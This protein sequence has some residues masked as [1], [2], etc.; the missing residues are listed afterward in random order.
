[1][2]RENPLQFISMKGGEEEFIPV[3]NGKKYG[4]AVIVIFFDE[5]GCRFA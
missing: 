2:P 4:A 5:Q 3:K 1:M